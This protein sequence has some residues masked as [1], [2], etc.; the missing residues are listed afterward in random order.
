M[1][2]LKSE[3]PDRI[4]PMLKTLRIEHINFFCVSYSLFFKNYFQAHS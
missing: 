1:N 3:Y 2:S 4:K